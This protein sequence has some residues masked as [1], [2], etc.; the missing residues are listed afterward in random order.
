ML[1]KCLWRP[2]WAGGYLDCFDAFADA[3]LL[4]VDWEAPAHLEARSAGLL[5]G[6]LLGRIDGKST[7]EYVTDE[8]DKN[9]TRK[10]AANLLRSP[11]DRLDLIRQRWAEG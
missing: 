7:V 10:F 5:P 1:L 11:V 8:T 2:Q 6:L 9:R 4:G 3:Y